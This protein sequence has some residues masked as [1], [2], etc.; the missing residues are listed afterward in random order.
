MAKSASM[1]S[2]SS[3]LLVLIPA[4]HEED[5]IREVVR[6]VVAYVPDVLVID[7]GSSDK[8]GAEAEAGGAVV[9][10]QEPNQGKGAALERGFHY[11]LDHGYAAVITMDADGQHSAE[12]LPGFIQAFREKGAD[13]VVGNRMSN[14]TDMPWIRR[15]TNCFMSWLLSRV[16]GQAIPD[17]QNGYRLYSAAALTQ[18]STMS[19]GFAAE[20]EVLL[21]LS[22]H[23]QTIDSVPTRTIYGEE[24]SKIHPIPDTYRFFRMLRRFKKE[25]KR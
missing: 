15:R 1:S 5:N 7:D 14:T 24:E 9:L 6:G 4:Y 10:R 17:S 16:A 19:N 21:R 2:T 3:S 25:Q 12:D 13:I 23:G 11:A 18:V 20:S 8:T 22:Q